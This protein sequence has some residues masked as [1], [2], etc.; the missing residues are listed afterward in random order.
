MLIDE[1]K[2]ENL[3]ALKEKDQIKKGILSVVIN[4]YMILSTDKNH[5]ES[6]VTDEEVLKLISKTLKELNEEKEGY[7]K[8]NNLSR[9]SD[10]E[11]QIDVLQAFLP[12]MMEESEIRKIISEIPDKSIPTVMKYF[13]Q[14]YSGKVDL[15]LVSKILKDFN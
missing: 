13:K 12:K 3:R 8:T 11:H 9:V 4:K 1:L 5:L 10:I 7:I 2:K 15:S 6:K 14:N